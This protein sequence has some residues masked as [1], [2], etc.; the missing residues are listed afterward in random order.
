[1]VLEVIDIIVR[2]QGSRTV[3]RRLE[4]IGNT[5]K[6]ATR[7]LRLLQNALFV[8]GAAGIVRGLTQLI[9]TL[10]VI[11]NRLRL[12][13]KSVA[14]HN[15]VQEEL[16]NVAIRTRTAYDSTARLF[17]RTALAVR[18]LGISLQ[19]AINFTESLN[20]AVILSGASNREANAAIIQLSQGL[21][22]ATLRGDELRSVM[23][24][25]PFVADIIGR[26]LVRRG[27]IPE[28]VLNEA[29]EAVNAI[30]GALFNT[31]GELRELGRDGRISAGIV[32]AAFRN[33]R[34][35]IAELFADTIP[36]IGQSFNVLGVVFTRFIDDFDDF[37]R[38]S[39][40][41]ARSIIALAG[42][43]DKLI[44]VVLS[45]IAA[46]ASFKFG[47]FLSG[48]ASV[49]RRN[50][51][52]SIA[53]RSGNATLLTATG[54]ER[55]KAASSLEAAAASQVN[56]AAKLREARAD[57]LQL[58]NQRTALLQQ[59]ALISIDKR[60]RSARD[61]LT[62]R[63]IV[64]RAS[65]EQNIRTNIALTRTEEALAAARGRLTAATTAQA[66]AYGGLTAAQGRNATAT[67]A[68]TG[69]L[70]RLS[71]AFPTL[72]LVVRGA[73][74]AV[75]ALFALLAAN[76]VGAVIAAIA[77]LAITF[78]FLAD[79]IRIPGE[80][81]VTLRD[82]GV[83][84]FQL[85]KES[86]GPV[87]DIVLDELAPAIQ[88]ISKLWEDFSSLVVRVLIRTLIG[89]KNFINITIGL[90]VGLTNSIIKSW[91]LLPAAIKD[92]SIILHNTFV[93]LIE[94]IVNFFLGLPDRVVEGFKD[95]VAIGE[96]TVESIFDAFDKLP[97]AIL[98]IARKAGEFLENTFTKA[99]NATI[100]VLNELPLVNL[101]P[102]PIFRDNLESFLDLFDDV[103]FS[104]LLDGEP[105]DLS[106]LKL[107][108]TGA[109]REVA[110]IFSREFA[111][112]LD[113]DYIGNAWNAILERARTLANARLADLG[114]DGEGNE[115]STDGD[116]RR[117]RGRRRRTF[118]EI[119]R[120]LTFENE[121]LRLNR[122][123]REKLRAV[124]EIEN[125]IKRQLT[126]TERELVLELLRENDVL[127]RAA[128]IYD[129]LNDPATEYRLT[130]EALTDLLETGR[131][132]Q[133]QFNSS[134][135]QARLDFLDT[136]TDIRSGLERG[137]LRILEDT[138]DLASQMESILT[139]A[140]DGIS[141]SIADLVVDGEANFSSLI[142]SINK[143][144]VEL[145][146]SQAFQQFA[147][148]TN[149]FSNLFGGTGAGTSYFPPAPGR[150]PVGNLFGLQ[151]GG[152][153]TVGS[154][155]GISPLPGNDN[156]LVAFRAQD[157]ENVTVTPRGQ[158]QNNSST[159]ITFNITTPDVQG[160][161]QSQSQLA[162]QAA[163]VIRQG[164]RNL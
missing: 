15:A 154:R 160:F 68:T 42:S 9:D 40:G 55:A 43:L 115:G 71:L 146:V 78:V 113:V 47:S 10:T 81:L 20:Q 162:A 59:Q 44:T 138:E 139:G 79:R 38:I 120:E 111:D 11:E 75:G 125:E 96:R 13:T 87:V 34:D 143:Q 84:T 103:N 108:T 12:V 129:E 26:E 156:R 73:I 147:G 16:F 88:S 104:D 99:V 21:A 82:V 116:G 102:I 144:I 126:I 124:F 3:R 149:L 35:E 109:A 29:G 91:D 62:G 61:R 89:I 131:I 63:F 58:L 37:T 45:A 142:R 60:R 18:G 112:A 46:F 77:V 48:A 22:S 36:T 14:E 49:I 24:Q 64:Y 107:P 4:Q 150:D 72:T 30:T 67:A 7:A 53:V 23:E 2:E 135:R 65:L 80:E 32:V 69:L 121:I 17:T 51:E 95:L 106:S 101:D 93:Q 54:I 151:R 136:Q 19:E 76:P 163:R 148:S 57:V 27:L 52:L 134:L 100:K 25:L 117:R 8:L 94:D 132:R 33:A 164:Q 98:R 145:L 110:N 105:L 133:D 123:E 161:R 140:F 127:S 130:L 83:A 158:A 5:A 74:S 6:N 70:A 1:M 31:R 114:G 137:Y 66:A 152:E 86:I 92:T 122:L 128:E 159:N 85:L 97:D 119:I 118:A 153:F 41:V 56:T 90:F 157:G 50:R 28:V 39:E 155:T 141:Q